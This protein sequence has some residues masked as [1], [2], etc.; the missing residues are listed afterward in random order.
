MIDLN[1]NGKDD[2]QEIADGIKEF[3]AK[4][5]TLISEEVASATNWLQGELAGLPDSAQQ[6]FAAAVSK[7]QSSGG[8][9]G[10]QIADT[11]TLLYNDGLHAAVGIGEDVGAMLK[12]IPSEVV[13]AAVG[14]TSKA[15]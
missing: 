7:A 6:F 11:L 10:E 3:I 15:P 14:I 1:K 8:T 5:A 2:V 12:A 9:L 13:T 4:E